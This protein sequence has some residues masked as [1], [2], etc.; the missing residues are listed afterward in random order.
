MIVLLISKI[1]HLTSTNE[2]S[3]AL[4]QRYVSKSA[5]MI[6]CFVF[7]KTGRK[8]RPRDNQISVTSGYMSGHLAE[9]I[10]II[11]IGTISSYFFICQITHTRVISLIWTKLQKCVY[12]LEKTW[13]D[14][15]YRVHRALNILTLFFTQ[16][17]VHV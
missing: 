1:I 11:V 8:P 5:L 6:V 16:S 14:D 7:H 4:Y 10:F 13:S 3:P 12:F 9:T 15:L 17:F 2:M